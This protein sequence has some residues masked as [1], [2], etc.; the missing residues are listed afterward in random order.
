MAG[1]TTASGVY[2]I[3]LSGFSFRLKVKMW[4]LWTK[5]L[6]KKLI[7]S[8]GDGIPKNPK[9]H[10]DVQ[11]STPFVCIKYTISHPK[12]KTSWP[13]VHKITIPTASVV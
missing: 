12:K 7:R 8:A 6:L 10:N 5:F 11:K 2:I 1:K 9:D 3:F 4:G 13:V